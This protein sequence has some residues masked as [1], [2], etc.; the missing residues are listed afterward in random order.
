MLL[1][2]EHQMAVAWGGTALRSR[3]LLLAIK[4]CIGLAHVLPCSFKGLSRCGIDAPR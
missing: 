1:N 4:S 2:V 3:V